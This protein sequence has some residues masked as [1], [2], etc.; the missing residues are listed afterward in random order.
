MSGILEVKKLVLLLA[1]STLMTG[2]REKALECNPYIQYSVQ[3]KRDMAWMQ[4]LINLGS[5]V[6]AIHP[7]F[8]KQ[9]SF[10]VQPT[11]VGV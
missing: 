5:E 2:V 1:S 8:A 3:F 6:N 10:L 7:T 9:L 4:V 11:V